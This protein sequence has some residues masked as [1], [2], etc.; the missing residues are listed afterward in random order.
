MPTVPLP[1]VATKEKSSL[2]T[3]IVL[4]ALAVCLGLPT[5]FLVLIFGN[6]KVVDP[7]MHGGSGKETQL[8]AESPLPVGAK[9]VELPFDMEKIKD[10]TQ[11]QREEKKG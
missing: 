8:S 5:L 10:D 4:L 6:Q 7:W 3:K 1:K 11:R 9:V 2:R